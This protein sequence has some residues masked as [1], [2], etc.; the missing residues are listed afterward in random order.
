MLWSL[1]FMPTPCKVEA[2]FC[3]SA[4]GICVTQIAKL[5]DATWYGPLVIMLRHIVFGF[6]VGVVRVCVISCKGDNF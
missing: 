4:V 5:T 1:D 3:F 6:A 2:T